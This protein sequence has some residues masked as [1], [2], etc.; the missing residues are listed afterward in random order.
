MQFKKNFSFVNF[1]SYIL[2]ILLFTSI[3]FYF[4]Y[5]NAQA[6]ILDSSSMT[7]PSSNSEN[8]S[9]TV[10]TLDDTETN[11]NVFWIKINE[12]PKCPPSHPIKGKFTGSANV[13]YTKENKFYNR[14][15]PHICFFSEEY[16]RDVAGFIKKF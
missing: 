5:K 8:S 3:G 12:E 14:V 15:T 2:F 11:S 7:S 1:I 4:G 9:D 6:S 16:A 13:F 10:L